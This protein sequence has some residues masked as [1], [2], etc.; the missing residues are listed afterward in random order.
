MFRHFNCFSPDH[1]T[2]LLNDAGFRDV[3]WKYYLNRETLHRFDQLLPLSVLSYPIKKTTGKWVLIPRMI[4]PYLF[5]MMLKPL[6]QNQ[7]G[8][9][10]AIFLV[11]NK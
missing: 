2:D 6:Y 11:A 7:N 10:A 5:N 9:G 8:P 4:L 3:E 1:W